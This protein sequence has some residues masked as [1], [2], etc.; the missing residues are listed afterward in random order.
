MDLNEE[1]GKSIN[2][3]VGQHPFAS[4]QE[5]PDDKKQRNPRSPSEVRHIEQ[6]KRYTYS[7]LAADDI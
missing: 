5:N 1:F 3:S 7:N 2:G 4:M 6:K